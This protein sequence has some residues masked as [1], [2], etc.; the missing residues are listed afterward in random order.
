MSAR[1]SG[2]CTPTRIFRAPEVT[3]VLES[4][5]DSL[6]EFAVR[7]AEAM[8]SQV[9]LAPCDYE[10]GVAEAAY[11]LAQRRG[12][13]PGRELEDGVDAEVQIANASKRLES[14]RKESKS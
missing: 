6:G 2:L 12:F 4:I 1:T 7:I 14:L 3:P 8:N 13:E 11:C 5:S 9:S 10:E